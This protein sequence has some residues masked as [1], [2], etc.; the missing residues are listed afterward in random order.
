MPEPDHDDP[1]PI[2]AH[3]APRPFPHF[4]PQFTRRVYPALLENVILPR[5]SL[6]RR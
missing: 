2:S 4:L 6:C 1:M 5:A 3:D